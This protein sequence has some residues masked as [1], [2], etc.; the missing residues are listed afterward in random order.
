MPN[1]RRE[2]LPIPPDTDDKLALADQHAGQPSPSS[3]LQ[4]KHISLAQHAGIGGVS[5]L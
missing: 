4:A 1:S 3:L 2:T 5:T